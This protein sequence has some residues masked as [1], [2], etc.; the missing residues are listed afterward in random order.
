MVSGAFILYSM[1]YFELEPSLECYNEQ[2][3]QWDTCKK[4][5]VCANGGYNSQTVRYDFVNGYG[6]HNWIE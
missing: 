6:L 4:N 2:T 1:N 3:K 5:Y